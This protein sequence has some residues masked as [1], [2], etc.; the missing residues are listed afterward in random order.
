MKHTLVRVEKGGNGRLGLTLEGGLLAPRVLGVD[1]NHARVALIATTAL[2]LAG[3]TVRLDVVVGPGCRLDLVD[4]A[5]TVAYG[6][7]GE[8][9]RWQASLRLESEAILT[10][11][12]EPFV[13]SAGAVVERELV[14]SLG[15]GSRALV[16]DLLVLGRAGQAGGDLMCRTRV[17]MEDGPGGRRPLLIEDLALDDSSTRLPGILGPGA[18][19]H[20]RVLDTV[21]ALGWRPRTGESDFELARAGAISRTL[22]ESAHTTA[23]LATYREWQ[24]DLP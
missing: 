18:G 14:A 7:R 10:W 4:V 12:G 22:A 16:R 20:A 21:T 5:G 19:R 2:L 23:G 11:P 15:S 6:G 17:E 9:S 24:Q 8:V 3:D 13:V 1:G